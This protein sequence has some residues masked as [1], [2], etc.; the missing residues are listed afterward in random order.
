MKK[1]YSTIVTIGIFVALLVLPSFSFAQTP[2]GQFGFKNDTAPTTTEEQPASSTAVTASTTAANIISQQEISAPSN[3]L[4]RPEQLP[5]KV[6]IITLFQDR[7]VTEYSIINTMAYWVQESVRDGVPANT[8]FLILLT[9]LLGFLVSFVR[10]VIGLPTLDMLVPI[11]LA[12][13]FVAVGINVGL[14]VL[15]AILIASY[16]SKKSLSKFKIMFYPKR[17]LSMVLLAISV[18]AALTIGVGLHFDRI[19]SVSIFP[20][21]VLMLLGDMIVSVQLHKSSFETFVITGTTIAIGLIG[22]FMATSNAIQGTVILYPEIILLVIPANL[23]IG[24][25]F[26]LRILELF[27]FNKI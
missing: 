9:P 19:L 24:R 7:P 26:G 5:E 23:A 4:T 11:A 10:V 3:D 15:G 6:A 2:V 20:I 17:S 18:F 22:Y 27:R 12:F 14:L 21:L 13:A 25:Y 8:I 16:I 1:T